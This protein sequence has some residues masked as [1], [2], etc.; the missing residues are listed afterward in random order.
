M[1][2]PFSEQFATA[3]KAGLDMLLGL[4]TKTLGSVGEIAELNWQAVKSTLAENQEFLSKAFSAGNPEDM[5]SLP[6]GMTQPA[7]DRAVSYGRQVSEI[8][9]RV[10]GDFSAT[11]AALAQQYLRGAQALFENLANKRPG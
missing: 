2:T 5:L 8:M 4:T 11:T 6:A 7:I 1:S 3:Q 9:L 10:Q